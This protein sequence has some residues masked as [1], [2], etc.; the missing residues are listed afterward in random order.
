MI[1][2]NVI[3]G[4]K[5]WIKFIRKPEAYLKR[6]INLLNKKKILFKKNVFFSLLLSNNSEIKK[7]N[8][9][10]RN[11]DKAT[12]VLSFPF[13]EKNEIKNLLKNNSE[14]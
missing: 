10:F 3:V 13:Y 5:N 6:K 1:K 12:D 2:V 7:I 14:F 11:K 9:K 8:K 4:N